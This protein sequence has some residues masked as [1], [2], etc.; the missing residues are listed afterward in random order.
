MKFPG[1]AAGTTVT[2]AGWGATCETCE[3]FVVS[4]RAVSK[5]VVSNAQCNAFY[6]G[7]VTA[8]KKIP[9]IRS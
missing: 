9:K 3:D 1:V 8:G 6:G 2:A 5:P 7:G 4:L